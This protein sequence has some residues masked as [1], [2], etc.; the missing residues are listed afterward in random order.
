MQLRAAVWHSL[1]VA[2]HPQE[3]SDRKNDED[4]HVAD[5]LLY[6]RRHLPRSAPAPQEW[7]DAGRPTVARGAAEKGKSTSG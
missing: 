3:Y 2:S 1:V 7:H 5:S 6:D 4:E